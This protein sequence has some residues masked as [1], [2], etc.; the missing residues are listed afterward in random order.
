[1]CVCIKHYLLLRSGGKDTEHTDLRKS[2]TTV[3][4][5]LSKKKKLREIESDQKITQV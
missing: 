4:I 5:R 3:I 2:I 1:M